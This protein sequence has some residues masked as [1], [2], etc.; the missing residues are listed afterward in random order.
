MARKFLEDRPFLERRFVGP[1][2]PSSKSGIERGAPSP[3][4]KEVSGTHRVG[5]PER[6]E[7]VRGALL[8]IFG[9]IWCRL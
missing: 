6:L 7:F 5:V 4:S 3:H 2:D 1:S 9:V 8:I